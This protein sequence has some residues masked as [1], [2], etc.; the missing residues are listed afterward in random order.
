METCFDTH[1]KHLAEALLMGAHV[2]VQEKGKYLFIYTLYLDLTRA[3]HAGHWF[4]G[5]NFF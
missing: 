1:E 3:I 5:T 4:L 2:F